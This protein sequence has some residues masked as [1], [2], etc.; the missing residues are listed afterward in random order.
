[1]VIGLAAKHAFVGAN[2]GQ[3]TQI[4]FYIRA[5]TTAYI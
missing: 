2:T 4:I 3:L 5:N 1:M